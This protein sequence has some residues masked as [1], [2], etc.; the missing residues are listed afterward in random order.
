M[1]TMALGQPGSRLDKDQRK[2]M[3]DCSFSEKLLILV[4][5]FLFRSLDLYNT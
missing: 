1:K 5:F 3:E 2:L 4:F